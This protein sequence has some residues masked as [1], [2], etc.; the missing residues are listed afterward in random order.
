MQSLTAAGKA[1]VVV[2][3]TT[4]LTN[5]AEY[6]D[7]LKQHDQEEA[8]TLI[9]LQAKHVADTNPFSELSHPILM[10]FFF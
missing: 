5:I 2:Y 9:I 10:S 1:F 7:E 6:P 4:C 3:D 8:D